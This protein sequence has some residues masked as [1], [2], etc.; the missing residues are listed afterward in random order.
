MVIEPHQPFLPGH[1]ARARIF[2]ENRGWRELRPGT[3]GCELDQIE[4][5]FVEELQLRRRQRR[6]GQKA[7]DALTP[8]EWLRISLYAVILVWLRHDD[9]HELDA[10][11]PPKK[12]NSQVILGKPSA[13]FH[14]AIAA[15]FAHH[16]QIITPTERNRLADPMWH[17]FRHY[18]PPELLLGFNTQHPAHEKGSRAVLG[19]IDPALTAWVTEQRLLAAFGDR[20]CVERRGPYPREIETFI[21]EKLNAHHEAI[22]KRRPQA[23]GQAFGPEDWPD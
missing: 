3:A 6:N 14:L 18:I 5:L 10:R 2:F 23:K 16:T 22:M 15:I 11:V 20:D 13:E 7:K 8:T 17:A 21:A 9:G 12:A 4:N 19:T 1:L